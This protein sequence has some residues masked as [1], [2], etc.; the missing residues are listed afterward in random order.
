M[1]AVA[2]RTLGGNGRARARALAD[3]HVDHVE[4][5]H[6]A[7]EFPPVGGHAA[8]QVGVEAGHHVRAALLG[9]VHGVL[10]RFLE[11][12]A[13]LDERDAQGAHGGVLLQRVAV[14]HD[15]GAGHAMAARGPAHA[16][17]V[18][19]ARG[20]DDFAGQRAARASWSK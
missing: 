14:R 1:R 12:V 19:A 11:V 16:L 13:M 18:V 2:Q 10:A 17:A 5:R 15:D 9:Q 20:A 8:Q 4:L 6:G 7:Q 3:G